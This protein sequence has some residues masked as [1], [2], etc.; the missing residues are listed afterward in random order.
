M[1]NY[2]KKALSSCRL[3]CVAIRTLMSRLL[4]PKIPYEGLKFCIQQRH[5]QRRCAD[6]DR[7]SNTCFQLTIKVQAMN[8]IFPFSIAR[9]GI[10]RRYC[11]RCTESCRHWWIALNHQARTEQRHELTFEKCIYSIVNRMLLLAH[12]NRFRL[13]L[14]LDRIPQTVY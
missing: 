1:T 9:D 12:K 8:V 3:H 13:Q 4:E 14:I 2:T 6:H 11:Q 5:F 7:P 10:P